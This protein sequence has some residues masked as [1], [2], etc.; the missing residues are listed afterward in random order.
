[1]CLSK[2]YHP[3][4][5]IKYAKKL[6]KDELTYS[7]ILSKLGLTKKAAKVCV[8]IKEINE[9]IDN[10]DVNNPRPIIDWKFS[11][12]LNRKAQWII[13]DILRNPVLYSFKYKAHKD[14]ALKIISCNKKILKLGN[15]YVLDIFQ[16]LTANRYNGVLIMIYENDYNEAMNL[17]QHSIKHYR[18]ISSVDGEI[19]CLLY[20]AFI[21][22]LNYKYNKKSLTYAKEYL[23]KAKKCSKSKFNPNDLQLYV[24][25]NILLIT[26]KIINNIFCKH[27]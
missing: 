26:K 15:D 18:N 23:N 21:E 4:L 27:L 1:M 12:S 19:R 6:Q 3:L 17:L 13:K 10:V 20:M 2:S 11:T 5:L 16:I 7:D 24:I 8:P 9:F 14:E 25:I 22:L